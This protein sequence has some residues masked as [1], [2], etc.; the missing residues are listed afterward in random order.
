[1]VAHTVIPL[2]PGWTNELPA[3]AIAKLRGVLGRRH[4]GPGLRR[5]AKA[6]LARSAR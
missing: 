2:S 4:H 6:M 1:M 3:S 5:P